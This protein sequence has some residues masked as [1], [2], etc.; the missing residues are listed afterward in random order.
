VNIMQVVLMWAGIT[1]YAVSAILFVVSLVMKKEG[2]LTVA[3]FV[4]AAGLLPHAVAIGMRWVQ[5][6][7]GPYM[8]FYEV[9]SGLVWVSVAIMVLVTL[10]LPQL[11]PVGIVVMPASFLLM[12]AALMAS[13]EI[14]QLPPTL[15]SY[16]LWIHIAFAKLT[17]GS[18]L[19]ATGL[20]ILY[21]LKQ[22]YAE[23]ENSVYKRLPELKQLDELSYRFVLLG[24]LFLGMMIVAGSIWANEAWGRYW[25]WDPIETWSFVGWVVY[26]IYLHQRLSRGWRGT[27]AAWLA[28]GA[29]VIVVFAL[30]GV[31][32]A[33][34]SVHSA[35]M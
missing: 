12:A 11:K 5:A 7:H 33:Y 30:L 16:W 23:K 14:H 24:F 2:L 17:Y 13:K 28:V 18:L 3:S 10:K 31:P 20:A 4:A 29:M 8:G 19:V 25:G 1:L 22:K 15:R 9:T 34:R 35:Y 32:F 27:K 21:L 26:G 6:G